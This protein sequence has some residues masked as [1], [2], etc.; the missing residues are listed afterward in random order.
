[1]T[2]YLV[3]PPGRYT[4]QEDIS[5]LMEIRGLVPDKMY[6]YENGYFWFSPYNRVAKQ[7]AHWEI[8]KQIAD[9]PGDVLEL[10]V[11]K[12]ASLIRWATFREISE[13]AFKRKIVGFDA[14]GEFPLEQHAPD[15]DKEFV[16]QF[17]S[18]GGNGLSLSELSSVIARKGLLNI[19]LIPGDVTSTLPKFIESNP[20]TRIA[21]LNLDLD[22]YDPT[23]I[24]LKVLWDRVMP[25]GIIVVDDYNSVAGA[26]RAVDEFL[27]AIQPRPKLLPS[28]FNSY[29]TYI[30]KSLD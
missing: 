3:P 29:P 14:F 11:Y 1:M 12:G 20:H 9:V 26:T 13:S 17:S 24:A 10:G 30:V 7:I 15:E 21:L 25:G 22:V 28:P 5:F 16:D 2:V 4:V 8:Y 18:A 6:D 19:H 23:L 27:S